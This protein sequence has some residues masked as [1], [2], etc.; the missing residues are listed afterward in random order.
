M[1]SY[2]VNNPDNYIKA[3]TKQE[4][5]TEYTDT[6]YTDEELIHLVDNEGL[7]YAVYGYLNP[8]KVQNEVTRKLWEDAHNALK[9]LAE[10]L[11]VGY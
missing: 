8:T 1:E 3:A 10:H 6:R 5:S 11:G 2:D 4:P 9:A 7:G